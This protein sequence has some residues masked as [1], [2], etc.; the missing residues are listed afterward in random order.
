MRY[1]HSIFD[2]PQKNND[3]KITQYHRKIILC[4]L[5]SLHIIPIVKM[6]FKHLKTQFL[7][8]FSKQMFYVSKLLAIDIKLLARHE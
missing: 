5:S 2:K 7:H 6:T 3:H 4:N 8:N 1:Y